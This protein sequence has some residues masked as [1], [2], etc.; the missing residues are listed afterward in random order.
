M[1]LC[2]RFEGHTSILKKNLL[3]LK[4]TLRVMIGQDDVMFAVKMLQVSSGAKR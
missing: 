3:F 1:C 2:S 4:Q